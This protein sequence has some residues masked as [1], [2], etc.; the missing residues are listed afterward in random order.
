M[1]KAFGEAFKTIDPKKAEQG[2]MS[3]IWIAFA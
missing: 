2:L 3:E 1:F